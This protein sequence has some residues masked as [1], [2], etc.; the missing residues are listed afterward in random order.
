MK[1]RGNILIAAFTGVL[2][3]GA[4]APGADTSPVRFIGKTKYLNNARAVVAHTI[5]DSTKYVTNCIDAMDKHG[6]KATIFVS[7][8]Q[9][10]AP[11]DRFFTQ[12][13]VWNLWPRLRQAIDNG[14]EIGS[15]ARTHPCGRPDTEAF[16]SA[17]YTDYE[18]TGSRDDILR[19]TQQPYVWTWCYPCGHC[20]NYDFI[21]KEIAAAGYI[22]ARNYPGEAQGRHI[23]PD[24]QSWDSNPYNAAY[25]QV[26]QK[27]G[28]AAKSEIIDVAILDAKFDEVYQRGGI[29]NFMSHPQWLD[30]G[31]EGF[32]ERHLAHISRRGDVWYVPMGPLYAYRTIFERTEVRALS[33]AAAK[34]RFTVSNDLDPKIY[35]GSITLEFRAPAGMAILSSG[36]KLAERANEMTDRWTQEYFRREGDHVYVTVQ[37]NTTLEFLFSVKAPAADAAGV[38]K[39]SY[40]NPDGQTRETTLNLKVDGDKVSGTIASQRG[41]AAISDGQV[42]GDDI[43][44]TV[45]RRGNGDEIQVTYKGKVEGETMKLTMQIDGRDPIQMTAKRGS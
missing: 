20:A 31:P 22:V 25:T 28:G 35:D 19:R 27:R 7:T 42:S 43:S 24:L 45:V 13:Q 38:W 21:Q 23:R 15:H 9:D 30:Y 39:A 40:T 18:V 26:V 4:G 12:L 14:H 3:S 1:I 10:P 6:I 33:P 8:E 29:Y 32:Y 36:R 44:F 2:V 5:D 16:C 34:A 17:A 11:E 41:S 37:S